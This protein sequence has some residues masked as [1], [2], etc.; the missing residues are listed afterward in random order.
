MNGPIEGIFQRGRRNDAGEHLFGR[1]PVQKI[2]QFQ[3]PNHFPKIRQSSSGCPGV[4]IEQR[5]SIAA[6]CEADRPRWLKRAARDRSL[7][8]GQVNFGAI[9]SK[10]TEY[11]FDGWAVY[12]WECCLK[13]PED[14]ARQGAEFIK[15]HIIR[16]TDK[17]FD[18]FAGVKADK[19]T[20][21]KMIGVA[22]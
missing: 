5:D 12:E 20:N 22:A 10:F 3:I 7:G 2:V 16:V 9:F 8:D 1:G 6:P 17:V 13:H 14:G 15:R 18:D 19:E 11:D 21:R 4:V